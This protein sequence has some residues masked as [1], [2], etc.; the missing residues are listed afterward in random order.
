MVVSGRSSGLCN[1]N[2]ADGSILEGRLVDSLTCSIIRYEGLQV[3]LT[4]LTARLRRFLQWIG[5]GFLG[6]AINLGK[7]GPL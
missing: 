1:G 2:M 5:W 3:V 6:K 4:V 7:F